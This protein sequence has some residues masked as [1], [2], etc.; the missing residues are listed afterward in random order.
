MISKWANTDITGYI[1]DVVSQSRVSCTFKLRFRPDTEQYKGNE[2]LM[3][4]FKIH[5]FHYKIHLLS[6]KFFFHRCQ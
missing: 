1:G 6:K 4:T 3:L 5:F 2:E